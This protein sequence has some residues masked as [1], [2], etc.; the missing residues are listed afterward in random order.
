M[1]E[2][3][4]LVGALIQEVLGPR[5][6]ASE[7]LPP[8][9][10][11]RDEYI[12]GALA[13][14][15]ALSDETD[16]GTEL[17]GE[18]DIAADDQADPGEDVYAPVADLA[19]LPSPTLDPRSRAASI[20]LSFAIDVS[21]TTTIDLCCTWARYRRGEGG[22]WVRDLRGEIRQAVNCSSTQRFT[23]AGDPGVRIDVRSRQQDDRLR[24]SVFLVNVTQCQG[25]RPTT[26]EHVFQPQIRIH[27]TEGTKLVPLEEVRSGADQEEAVL[28][29]L[30]R[31][32]QSYARGHLCAA[33]WRSVDPE[34]PHPALPSPEFAPFH[35]T[36]GA[37]LF[38]AATVARF[39]P[40]D[41]R[42]ELVPV[43]QISAPDSRW[44]V[45]EHAPVLD[46]EQLSELWDA[47]QL[48]SA[49]EP[50]A[51]GYEDW[52]DSQQSAIGGLPA[53]QQP[54][55][56]A[57]LAQCRSAAA[58]IRAGID[59]LTSDDDARLAF[60]FAN[61]TIALQSRWTK[62]RVNPWWP[63]QLAFQLLNLSAL[64][65]P[66][67]DDRDICDLLWF[68]TGGGKTEAYLGLAAFTLALR[69]LR[70]VR[71][72]TP[73][74][75]G[76]VTVLS[77]YTLRLL[78]IQQFRRALALITACEVLRTQ[79]FGT[80]RGWRPRKSVD[81][82]DGLWGEGRFSVGLWAGGN[83]TPNHLH[84][85]SY[86]DPQG[87]IINVY[88]ALTDLEGR[89]DSEGEPAQVL[90]C[91]SCRAML[92]IP[93]EGYQRGETAT[94]HF[95]LGDVPSGA[96][97]PTAERLSHA[98]FVV[99]QATLVREANPQFATLSVEFT[100]QDH[101][102]PDQ[103][104]SWFNE[105]VQRQLPSGTWLVPARPARP[106]YFVRVMDWGRRRT[107]KP[108]DF[109]I[110]CPNPRCELN[111]D[112]HWS[113][114]TPGG[115][116]T[117][118][119]AFRSAEGTS[120]HCP[121]PA[122]TVD[123][124][125]YHRCP[126][127]LVATV[128]K[129]AR[130]SFESR[131]GALFG[132]VD[133]YSTPLGYYR[134]W[135]PPRGP[136]TGLPA[137]PERDAPNTPHVAVERFAPPDLILQDELHLIDGPLGSMVG[138]YE[139]AIDLLSSAGDATR[140][141]RPKYIA[142]TATVRRA[143]EQVLAVFLR[144]L[145]VFPPTGMEINDS[146]FART[147]PVHPLDAAH[148]GRLY[149]GV[150]AP[151]RG[152]QTPIV[153]IWSRLLQHLQDRRTAG[154]PDAELDPFWTLVGYFNAIRELA[155]GVSLARQDIP[156]RIDSMAQQT[157]T[158]PRVLDEHEPIELSSR[159][160]SMTLPGLLAQLEHELGGGQEPVN[161]AVATSMFGTGVDVLR[162]GLMIVHGQPKMTSSYI[163]A[164]GRVGRATGGMVVTFF[165]AA[166]PRDLSH[167][168]YFTTYHGSLYRFVEPVTVYPFA[169]RARDRALGPVSVALLRQASQ[170]AGTVVNE[171][172][173]LQQRLER[174]SGV[175]ACRAHEM[176]MA[177][178][179]ADVTIIPG[180]MEQRAQGQPPGR[181]PAPAV[182]A[183]HA[184]SELDRWQ[185]VAAVASG[186]LLYYE[187]TMVNPPSRSVVL[188]DLAHLVARMG[189]VYEDAPNSLREV[190]STITIQGWRM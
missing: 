114:E 162:L 107:E 176:E 10:D 11:P 179:D 163:Q 156:Q 18:E 65:D 85:F 164:T 149:V 78:T 16:S 81:K 174:N 20:G 94:L 51:N 147:E 97:T 108:F 130:L 56:E 120:S 181:Q 153:R 61:K 9:Q 137:E 141:I 26:E 175:W 42:T 144:R 166:R 150:C 27:C 134:T 50:L 95:V 38:D 139:S 103:V 1:A 159:A 41:A 79:Q 13:P 45:A 22:G 30:Y 55:A 182:T 67:H 52:I 29:F 90:H 154:V 7:M 115:T 87:R 168:E 184:S 96:Q 12:T 98:P 128:D 37:S 146:F 24:V 54:L 113:E 133:R 36:D 111:H 136:A 138:I 127:M 71:R 3:D 58:R 5:A 92:A 53:D 161:I 155:G 122:W 143:R 48:R 170:I 93:P 80:A 124:Q 119:E 129:F 63:F 105:H 82:T 91:P 89:G 186:Q 23:P 172:W 62:G 106:G 57:Q 135:A 185:Q 69:R 66:S 151:G 84:D 171:R 83:V 60:C 47:S 75:G 77:R 121:I 123:E 169:P 28:A 21:G 157:G 158:P 117:A 15:A 102:V 99:S 33:L 152:A 145:A 73:L 17:V 46:P 131:A 88:G 40:A 2:R 180:Q 4:L 86:R 8:D 118:L 183:N 49:L 132:N 188:G 6:N 177:R 165:R 59:V 178:Q 140:L 116:W 167:Y 39:S 76:G 25:D 43:F 19:A 109:E 44:R 70:A 125:V 72:G 112:I 173:R 104:D 14:H 190:E 34:R 189:V 142:S 148:R 110:Y 74:A 32:C 101:V 64:R 160:G 126:S 100:V 31:N 35:W 68:P 187:P